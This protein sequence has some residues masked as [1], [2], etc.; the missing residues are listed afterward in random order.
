MPKLTP[1]SISDVGALIAELREIREQ[2][3]AR[4]QNEAIPGL[5]CVAAPVVVQ[6][7]AVAALSI[8]FRTD[9]PP[10]TQINT[11]LRDTAGQIARDVRNSLRHSQHA[12]WYRQQI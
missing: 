4:E 2:R 11:V 9:N 7:L 3:L 6:G 10:A 12:N 8:G 5:S 1:S